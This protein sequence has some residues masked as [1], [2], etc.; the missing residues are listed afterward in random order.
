[1]TLAADQRVDDAL[2][3]A[4]IIRQSRHALGA[5]VSSLD[6]P[7]VPGY[8][9]AVAETELAW[10]SI[11]AEFGLLSPAETSRLLG[12]RGRPGAMANERR[13]SGRLMAVLHGNQ[14][15]YP[16]FQFDRASGRTRPGISQLIAAARSVDTPDEDL[17]LWLCAPSGQLGARRPVDL[18][19]EPEVVVAAVADHFGVEW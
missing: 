5:A 8:A 18:L 16:G 14:Y 3:L 15:Q 7:V 11:E 12:S 2:S 19:N 10:R 13:L 17:I 1:M 9:A 6:R 4:T